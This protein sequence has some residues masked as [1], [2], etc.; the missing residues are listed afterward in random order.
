MPIVNYYDM[1][2]DFGNIRHEGGVS[3]NS[4]KKP[5]KLLEKIISIGSD[6]GDLVL[7]FHLGSGTTAAVAHKMKRRYIGIEQLDYVEELSVKR[8]LNVINGDK[9]GI[10]EK[11]D[12]QGGGSFIYAELMEKNKGFID[13]IRKCETQNDID[14]LF[15]FLLEEAEID[16]R[17]DL[18]K[19]KDTLHELSLD[20]QKKTLFKIIE[21]NQ[22]YYNYS[23]IDDKNVRDLI[24][25]SDYKFNKSFY[26]GGSDN[27]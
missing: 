5:E 23:E 2:G 11:Y 24:S 1:S 4:G 9:T 8:L 10:S 25:D 21:K 6:E 18:E 26:E 3:L 22:L 7:D 27:E 14:Q 19:V 20:D 13:M 15:T 12:W 17:V 16:F